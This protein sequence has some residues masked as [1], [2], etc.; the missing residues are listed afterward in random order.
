M[1]GTLAEWYIA[2]GGETVL[3][4]KPAPLIYAA[5]TALAPGVPPG[6]WLAVGDSLAHD[7]AG[8]GAAGTGP[9]CFIVGG[10]HAEEARLR[11]GQGDGNAGSSWDAGAVAALVQEHCGGGPP[12]AYAAAWMEW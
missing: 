3:M 9:A 2:G 10:I 5:A 6:R 4:G 8:A 1:P 11:G 12:P 7:V